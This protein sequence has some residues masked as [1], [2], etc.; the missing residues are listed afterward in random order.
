M[1]LLIVVPGSASSIWGRAFTVIIGLC[2]LGIAGGGLA[3][4]IYTLKTSNKSLA[5]IGIA[6]L[7]FVGIAIVACFL[8]TIS[9][10]RSVAQQIQTADYHTTFKYEN[11]P[12]VI[13]AK[14]NNNY[15]VSELCDKKNTVK[16]GSFRYVPI[17][18]VTG[19]ELQVF[20]LTP[21]YCDDP[22]RELPRYIL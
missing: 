12:Y 3:D 22:K 10:T 6:L 11:K 18:K 2:I 16:Y 8:L 17:E 5:S 20:A 13:I 9:I 19:T 21:R 1:S 7:K 15:L 4:I 14:E